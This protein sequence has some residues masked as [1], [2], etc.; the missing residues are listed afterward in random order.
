MLSNVLKS[1][2][3]VKA[4]IQIIRVFNKMREMVQDH[5][6][7]LEKLRLA[8]PY[9]VVDFHHLLHAGFC[10]RF[11]SLPLIANTNLFSLH[12]SYKATSGVSVPACQYSEEDIGK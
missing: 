10:R 12:I 9:H 4:S 7:L 8:R 1:E 5:H 6:T 2:R 11:L 3:A